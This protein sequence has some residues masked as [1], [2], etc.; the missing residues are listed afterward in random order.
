[1]FSHTV[2]TPRFEAAQVLYAHRQQ[3]NLLVME[4]L[5]KRSDTSAEPVT[6]QLESSFKPQSDDIVFQNGPDY[7]GG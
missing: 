5:L 6:I 2:V 3:S 1:V 7:K 4:V